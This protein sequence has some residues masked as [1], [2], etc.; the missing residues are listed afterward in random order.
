MSH[1]AEHIPIK[2]SRL[3]WIGVLYALLALVVF[4]GLFALADQLSETWGLVLKIIGG[5]LGALFI[6]TGAGALKLLNDKNAGLHLHHGG[7][8]D[9]STAI[10]VG[11]VSW[12][13][14]SGF[15]VHEK[16]KLIRVL[17]RNPQDVIKSAQNRAIRQLLE[18]NNQIY[19]TPVILESKYLN[20]STAVLA[21][22]LQHWYKPGTKK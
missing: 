16:E 21:E 22:R 2:R 10:A 6:L 3:K 12:K 20:C 15:E 4:F 7:F 9:H 17:L 11:H 1:A 13:N 18:R 19:K 14:V 8:E 5:V